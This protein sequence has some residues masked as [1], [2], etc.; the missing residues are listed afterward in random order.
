MRCKYTILLELRYEVLMILL[1]AINEIVID[2]L[3]KPKN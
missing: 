2:Y 1:I 3:Q